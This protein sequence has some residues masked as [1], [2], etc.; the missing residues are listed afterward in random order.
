M[1]PNILSPKKAVQSAFE[2]P[3]IG[4]ALALVLVSA[5]VWIL[6]NYLITGKL[7]AG[8]SVLAIALSFVAFFI[9]VLII[10]VLGFLLNRSAIRG[11]FTGLVSGLSLLQIIM[12]VI[13]LLSAVAFTLAI[14]PDAAA[15]LNAVEGNYFTTAVKVR[16]I[17][18]QN[19]DAINFTAISGFLAAA[20]LVGLYGFYILFLIARKFTET[21]ILGSLL[22]SL[23]A[24]VIAAIFGF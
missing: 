16:Q 8:A 4:L 1:N 21:G 6:Q 12:I 14:P 9:F 24:V 17:L 7:D 11:K 23:V 22:M 20:A 3:S 2:K 18:E 5:V 19:A 10:L 15:E 13:Y